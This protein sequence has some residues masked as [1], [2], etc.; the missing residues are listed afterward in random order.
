MSTNYTPNYHLNQW[1]P[2][3]AVLRADF[4]EDNAKIDAAIKAV[5]TAKA[6]KSALNT[7]SGKVSG[8]ASAIAKLGNCRI[9]SFTYTG[10][11]NSGSGGTTDISFSGKPV[12]FVILQTGYLFL[13]DGR[14][15][16]SCVFINVSGETRLYTLKMTWS[17]NQ[18]H[19]SSTD[20]ELQGNVSGD[21]YRVIA[22]YSQDGK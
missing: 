1:E 19:L 2:G 8:N 7:L 15:N 11:G 4:N 13:G 20:V 14:G 18:C 21:T 10:N 6:D 22:F 16:E 3:D 9:E 5:D 12:F 17:G